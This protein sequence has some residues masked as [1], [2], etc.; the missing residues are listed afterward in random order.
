MKIITDR[1]IYVQKSD[2]DVLGTYPIPMPLSIYLKY[3]KD[4]MNLCEGN[5][6]YSFIKFED[7]NEI[8]FFKKLNWIVDYDEYKQ[9]S[10][11]ELMELGK[12]LSHKSRELASTYEAMSDEEKLDNRSLFIKHELLEYKIHSI[13]EILWIKFRLIRI[14]IPEDIEELD[15]E[16]KCPKEHNTK[17]LIKKFIKHIS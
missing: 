13:A 10:V 15:N 5:S 3:C 6:V 2:I 16:A 1:C 8:E 17:R 9:L 12:N 11:D 4:S 7:K 14:S